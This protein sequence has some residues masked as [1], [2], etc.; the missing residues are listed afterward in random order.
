MSA[1]R[2]QRKQNGKIPTKTFPTN[3][4]H[5]FEITVRR[6]ISVKND[7]DG[8]T[9]KSVLNTN[10]TCKKIAKDKNTQNK[11]N[12]KWQIDCCYFPVLLTNSTTRALTFLKFDCGTS[13]AHLL[14]STDP[15]YLPS[16]STPPANLIQLQFD[17][18][19]STK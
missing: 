17:S 10:D 13:I 2:F 7:V 4:P 3:F 5:T 11:R 19:V 16:Y 12:N 18:K 8:R 6:K 15:F 9:R 14:S 1:Q